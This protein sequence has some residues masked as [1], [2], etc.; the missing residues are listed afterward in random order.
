MS[1]TSVRSTKLKSSPASPNPHA[2]RGDLAGGSDNGRRWQSVESSRKSG[3]RRDGPFDYTD[4]NRVVCRKWRGQRANGAERIVTA[5]SLDAASAAAP[6][7]LSTP[8][9][10]FRV[11]L[12]FPGEKR[13]AVERIADALAKTYGRERI[14]YDHYHIAEFA[15]PNLDVLLPRLYVQD[16]DLIVV[17]LCPEYAAKRWCNLEWR[18]IRQL[19]ATASEGRIMFVAFGDPGDLSEIGILP[20]DG[21][22]PI[23]DLSAAD[24]AAL[25]QARIEKRPT[26]PPRRRSR[27]PA[28]VG[29]VAVFGGVV[30]GL[31][32]SNVVCM[33]LSRIGRCPG[34]CA[35]TMSADDIAE[36][37]R[38]RVTYEAPPPLAGEG[39]LLVPQ[40]WLVENRS[41]RSVG[42]MY[43][44]LV[45]SAGEKVS[46]R[47]W[48]LNPN[49]APLTPASLPVELPTGEIPADSNGA[50]VVA[51]FDAADPSRG[52]CQ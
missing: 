8:G 3:A 51:V 34:W 16:A 52:T 15:V 26:P 11:A 25:I 45:G 37:H 39:A 5:E 29:S 21:F 40:T 24:A 20:G 33:T 18:H 17:F 7:S 4:E 32:A 22:A 10:R 44:P 6:G 27:R 49:V 19:L 50:W 35:S 14:L 9:R 13:D 12:T 42:L 28:V 46:P 1:T 2:P 23:G 47:S 41:G 43:G 48:D 30:W 31:V 36:L 38:A